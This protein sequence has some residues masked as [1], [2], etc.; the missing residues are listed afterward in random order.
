MDL[1]SGF[2]FTGVAAQGF[3]DVLLAGCAVGF[4]KGAVGMFE[5]FDDG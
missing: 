1:D 2:D 4:E 5:S 3:D